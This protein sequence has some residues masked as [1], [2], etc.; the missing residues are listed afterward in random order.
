[1]EFEWAVSKW[2]HLPAPP[3]AV[4]MPKVGSRAEKIL[5]KK[6]K[7][8]VDKLKEPDRSQHATRLETFHQAAKTPTDK[9]RTVLT[10][11]DQNDLA[12]WALASLKIWTGR[13]FDAA[14]NGTATVADPEAIASQ[15]S[16]QQ[17]GLLGRAEQI[18]AAKSV[19]SKLASL[20]DEPAVCLLVSGGEDAEH[21]L[22]L[23]NLMQI[24]AICKARPSPPGRPPQGQYDSS[25]LT[26]WV[27]GALGVTNTAA[28][29]G[30]RE[31]AEAVAS[32]LKMQP[33][34]FL[35]DQIHRLTGG[36]NSFQSQFWEPFQRRLRE[37]RSEQHFTHRLTAVLVEYTGES[38]AWSGAVTPAGPAPAGNFDKLI[39]LP[40]L[41]NIASS[42]VFRWCD[43][44]GA[45]D[46]DVFR[47]RLADSILHDLKGKPDGN[48]AR[49]YRRLRSETVWPEEGTT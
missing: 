31:L 44:V 23:K 20:D 35:L 34:R 21:Q 39:L 47:R 1:M 32:E 45:P 28:M 22:F 3:L 5:Q 24:P 19:L 36:V 48:A 33:L 41:S 17:L 4:M 40:V 46:D 2:G 15:V 14:A 42:D 27:A 18:E 8:L 29:A 11:T 25:V 16:E 38:S 12:G 43:D 49:V 6:A 9:W 10:F 30:P 37:L 26:S 7:V 13:S